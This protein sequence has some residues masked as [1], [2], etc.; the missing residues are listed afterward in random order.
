[1]YLA[2]Y[3]KYRPQT[4]D[5][6]ISQPH[7]T[8]TLK[9]QISGGKHGHAYLFTGSRGTGKTT[10]AKILSMAVNC[11]HP[12][13]GNPCMECDACREIASGSA[14]D[15]TEMD[16]ASNNGVN[17]VRVLRD[18]VAYTPVSCKYRVY[19]IDEVH[20]MSTAAFNALLKTLEEPPAHIIFILA[21]TELHKVPATIVSRCQRFEFRRIDVADSAQRLMAV[22]HNEGITLEQDAAELIS[23]LSDGGM[24]DAL[25]VLDRCIAA[26]GSVTCDVVRSCAGVA[27]NRHLFAFA[28]MIA[29]KNISGCL[30][31]MQQ[32][33]N[34]SKDLARLIDE[35]SGHYRDLMLY[36]TVPED[37][38]LL[39]AMPDEY[40]ELERLSSMYSLND[41]L[42]C[43]EQLQKCAVSI[44]RTRHRKTAAEMTLVRMC[45]GTSL[46]SEVP[47]QS[48]AVAQPPK[49]VSQPMGQDLAPIPDEKLSPAVAAILNKTRALSE[50]MI[51]RS[52]AQTEPKPVAPAPAKPVEN[53][54]PPAPVVTEAKPIQTVAP[55]APSTPVFEEAPMPEYHSAPAAMEDDFVPP[56]DDAPE[57]FIPQR[58]FD[59]A[60][61]YT[62]A[63]VAQ[64]IIQKPESAPAPVEVKPEPAE[65]VTEVP[66]QKAEEVQTESVPESQPEQLLPKPEKLPDITP[67]FWQSC[68]ELMPG[69]TSYM[70]TDSTAVVNSDGILEIHSD[71]LLLLNQV[72]ERGYQELEKDISSIIGKNVRAIVVNET[73]EETVEEKNTAV[74]QLLE[75]ARTL[76]IET[77][78]KN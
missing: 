33:Y 12:K 58:E 61:E 24:R 34:G 26:G 31:L 15:I 56:P 27:D 20:M 9:N 39:S 36:K 67:E 32:L 78:I 41:I 29:Q 70:L 38:G 66:V 77:E 73:K 40:P 45:M 49:P 52:E 74:K 69:M 68:V 59:T 7:I 2:L 3:R 1:M 13:D 10:C 16:A 62:S 30:D 53:V 5:D 6:V 57:E 71:N 64:A 19:I 23:R 8:T 14:V 4:F 22:A 75:K 60:P 50:E 47:V 46:S 43:L 55:S 37:K 11:L 72:K 54:A 25:S 76:G 18:E 42:R 35:L 65:V 44:G 48:L 21:T 17:D 63:P 51:K 28:E